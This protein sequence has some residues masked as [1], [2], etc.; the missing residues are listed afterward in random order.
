MQP[1]EN[2]LP[3]WQRV[4]TDLPM[5]KLE[6]MIQPATMSDLPG[7]GASILKGGVKGRVVVDLAG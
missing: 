2:R 3:A 7:L 6:A 4:V 5:D 1:Y